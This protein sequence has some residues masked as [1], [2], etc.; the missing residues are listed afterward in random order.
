MAAARSSSVVLAL[1]LTGPA[2]HLPSPPTPP[3]PFTPT[4]DVCD[5]M[6]PLPTTD[7]GCPDRFIVIGSAEYACA[8]CPGYG[9][10]ID[11]GD[12]VY[13]VGAGGCDECSSV[14]TSNLRARPPPGRRRPPHGR[15]PP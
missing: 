6:L 4:G 12:L 2:C 14:A 15:T 5:P 10:C 9:R 1:L 3:P 11:A 8:R 7:D 13:C